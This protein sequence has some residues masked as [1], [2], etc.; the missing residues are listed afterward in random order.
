MSNGEKT[1]PHGVNPKTPGARG[2][3]T[4]AEFEM[5]VVEVNTV[6]QIATTGNNTATQ[7]HT[8]LKNHIFPYRVMVDA[9]N[10][11]NE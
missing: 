10:E 8:F 5:L 9:L 4:R 2:E 11:A 7:I 3:I 1:K 6:R